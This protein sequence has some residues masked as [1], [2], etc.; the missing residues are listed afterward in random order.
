MKLKSSLFSVHTYRKGSFQ[1][2][3]IMGEH[4]IL[5]AGLYSEQHSSFMATATSKKGYK[6]HCQEDLFIHPSLKGSILPSKTPERV[7]AQN[8]DVNG[9][10]LWAVHS[11]SLG[12]QEVADPKSKEVT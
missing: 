8:L 6:N 12:Q 3:L 4:P 9:A 2:D 11:C 1:R 7:L 10:L 5:K